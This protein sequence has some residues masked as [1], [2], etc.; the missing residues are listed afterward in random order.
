MC[1]KDASVRRGVVGAVQWERSD[2]DCGGI[3]SQ[4][5]TRRECAEMDIR[6]GESKI[7]CVC[8]SPMQEHTYIFHS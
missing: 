6:E 3:N 8:R 7:E 1:M 5:P 4:P 2:P